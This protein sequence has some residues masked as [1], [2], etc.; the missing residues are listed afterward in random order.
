MI[1]LH[2]VAVFEYIESVYDFKTIVAFENR[3]DYVN[4][5]WGRHFCISPY[6]KFLVV[7]YCHVF[8]RL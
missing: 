1:W 4:H 7:S 3:V 6:P 5:I 2:G 8:A